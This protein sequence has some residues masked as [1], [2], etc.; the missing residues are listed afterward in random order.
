MSVRRQDLPNLRL[1][2]GAIGNLL[3]DLFKAGHGSDDLF[4][5]GSLRSSTQDL[6]LNFET[7]NISNSEF[8]TF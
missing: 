5:P 1:S 2:P 7:E 4:C 6:G 3:R 8:S